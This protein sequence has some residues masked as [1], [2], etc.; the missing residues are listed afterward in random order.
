MIIYDRLIIKSSF[1]ILSYLIGTFHIN[2]IEKKIIPEMCCAFWISRPEGF[3]IMNL[4]GSWD[5]KGRR[6]LTDLKHALITSR[7]MT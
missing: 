2:K 4:A 7:V 5:P 1:I 6:Q 3:K